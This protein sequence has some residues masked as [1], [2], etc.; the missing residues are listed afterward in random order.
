MQMYAR[1]T[2]RTFEDTTSSYTRRIE[3]DPKG[4]RGGSRRG[5]RGDGRTKTRKG[6]ALNG[7]LTTTGQR[8]LPIRMKSVGTDCEPRGLEG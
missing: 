5:R 7:R 8:A 3:G 2:E 6:T 1:G 4:S